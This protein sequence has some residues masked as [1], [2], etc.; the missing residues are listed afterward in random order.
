MFD[1]FRQIDGLIVNVEKNNDVNE[2]NTT[3]TLPHLH[4][5]QR[6]NSS[7]KLQIYGSSVPSQI[8]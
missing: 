2:Y 7:A 1:T 3:K 5:Q 4:I 8:G 6:T